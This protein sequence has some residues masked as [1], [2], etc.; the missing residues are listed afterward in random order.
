[1]RVQRRGGR[2]CDAPHRPPAAR[3]LLIF[4][5]R[6]SSSQ[7]FSSAAIPFFLMSSKMGLSSGSFCKSSSLPESLSFA[8]SVCNA[9]LNNDTSSKFLVMR[10]STSSAVVLKLSGFTANWSPVS[11]SRTIKRPVPASA[12][13]SFLVA[14]TTMAFFPFSSG[15]L[16]KPWMITSSPGLNVFGD[17]AAGAPPAMPCMPGMPCGPPMAFENFWR[18]ASFFSYFFMAS[19]PFFLTSSRMSFSSGSSSIDFTADCIF[20][21]KSSNTFLF[22]GSSMILFTSA[23]N[24]FIFSGSFMSSSYAFISKFSK[25]GNPALLV[26]ATLAHGRE[27]EP[28]KAWPIDQ[29]TKRPT[30]AAMRSCRSGRAWALA[31]NRRCAIPRGW[32]KGQNTTESATKDKP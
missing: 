1:M 13:F 11:S 2:G 15:A 14:G 30:N 4:F 25:P 5:I 8:A 28:A 10:S 6:A 27:T 17:V 29:Q 22:S 9:G 18:S 21:W 12:S 19:G 23:C 16:A 31:R 32:W 24:P 26:T 3:A 7:Y 20:V